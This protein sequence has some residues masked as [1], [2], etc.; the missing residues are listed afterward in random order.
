[1]APLDER[2]PV[3]VQ[4]P[5]GKETLDEN[6]GESARTTKAHRPLSILCMHISR[7]PLQVDADVTPPQRY[8]LPCPSCLQSRTFRLSSSKQIA[9]N[10]P[11]QTKAELRAAA[12]R[13]ESFC[14]TNG[15]ERESGGT[16]CPFAQTR[17]GT[18]IWRVSA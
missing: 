14:F 7:S 12:L 4:I 13:R 6:K 15:G 3:K 18:F 17:Q 8:P 2:A 10:P 5:V 1:M 11:E 9:N 16:L